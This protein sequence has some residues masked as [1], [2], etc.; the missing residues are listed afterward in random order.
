MDASKKDRL[1]K[2]G[3][4]VSDAKEFL[5]LSDEE[6]AYIEM[7]LDMASLL[8][9]ERK[10][11]GLTQSGFAKKLHTSQPRIAKMENG[12]P[13]VTLD[14]ILKGLLALQ[15]RRSEIGQALQAT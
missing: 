4:K 11:A 14:L 10:K 7:K 8:K 3:W 13:S 2:A 12:D 6:S 5:N 1:E 9:T 15:V